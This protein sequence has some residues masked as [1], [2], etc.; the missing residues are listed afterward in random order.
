MSPGLTFGGLSGVGAR[1]A[2][3]LFGTTF[4]C[5]EIECMLI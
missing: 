5:T 3:G 1:I 2:L 4:L